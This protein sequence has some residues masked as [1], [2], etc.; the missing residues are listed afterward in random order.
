MPYLHL[1]HGRKVDECLTDW[2]SDGPIFGP[3]DYF[4]TTYAHTI[5][6]GDEA[7][8]LTIEEGLVRYDGIL[9]G[10]WSIFSDC[11]GNQQP[12]PFDQAKADAPAL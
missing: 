9:Y 8:T 4:H 11:T 12:V 10:D 7:H 2:G 3:F 5:R 1:F 6:F